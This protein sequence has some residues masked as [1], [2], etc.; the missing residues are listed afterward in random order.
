MGQARLSTVASGWCAEAP[1]SGLARLATLRGIPGV[2]VNS[3]S[4]RRLWL[5]GPALTPMVERRLREVL[6]CRVYQVY[7]GDQLLAVGAGVPRGHVRDGEWRPLDA[8]LA[9][10]RP[11]SRY[12]APTPVAAVSLARSSEVT[13]AGLALAS[14]AAWAKYVETAPRVRLD[15]LSY[16][17]SDSQVVIVGKP[18]PPL[19]AEL[20][21]VQH[22]VAAPVGYHWMP[23][24]DARVLCEA[25]KLNPGD[26]LLLRPSGV[27]QLVAGDCF[28][29][30]SRSSVR[31]LGAPH[32]GE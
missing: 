11:A 29:G 20:F 21:H 9:L 32:G 12:A 2:E 13:T 30:A 22:G 15:R 31:Q 19:R 1:L 14:R 3:A 5:R 10:A 28:V 16:A 24:L 27:H 17:A 25:W 23:R 8:W 4:D 26:Y 7:A 18:L 6:G